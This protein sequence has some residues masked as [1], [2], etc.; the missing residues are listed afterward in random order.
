MTAHKYPI[1]VRWGEMDALGHVNNAVYLQYFEAARIAWFD[2][3]ELGSAN[4]DNGPVVVQSN[5]TY[6]RPVVYPCRLQVLTRLQQV[7]N[8][9]FV[10]SQ[11][12]HGCS[13]DTLYA[14]ASITC[15]WVDRQTG[16][17]A[18]APDFLRGL[19]DG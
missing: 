4:P 12:L 7:G 3:G 5:C 13:D 14:E 19:L 9:S 2:S 1:E 11:N 6:H 17:P 18:R 16:R 10:L 15:V 8:S